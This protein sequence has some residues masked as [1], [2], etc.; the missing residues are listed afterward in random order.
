MA[1]LSPTGPLLLASQE[2]DHRGVTEDSMED[3]NMPLADETPT[4]EDALQAQV[5]GVTSR[6]A[7]SQ[8]AA[9]EH[10]G[11]AEPAAA[12]AASAARPEAEE[13]GLEDAGAVEQLLR[14]PAAF[15][16]ATEASDL[17]PL[18]RTLLLTVAAGAGAF[19]AV[20]GAFRGGVQVAY[21]ALK[22]P[23]LLVGTMAICMPSFVA[24][25]RAMEIKMKAREVVAV[26][27]GACAR[28][29]LVLA[30]LS[31]VIWLLEGWLGYHG[32]VLAI[33]AACAAAG[34]SAAGLLSRGLT[35]RGGGALAG[36]AFIAVFGVVGGQTSWL[37][38]P[39][40]V[41]PRTTQVPFLRPIEGDLLDAVRRSGRSAA[42]VYEEQGP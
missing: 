40:L 33:T 37:L 23:L 5:A 30:G 34:V 39:F 38:R 9:R 32:V 26:T 1:Q 12:R 8:A 22:V 31:P 2:E 7:T 42:G 13:E 18:A 17:V 4:P 16:G 20:M 36:L 25:A 28:F 29:S 10:P 3:K 11:E 6:R 19:G 27:L 35:R 24:L 21:G 15:L 14:D 41:R